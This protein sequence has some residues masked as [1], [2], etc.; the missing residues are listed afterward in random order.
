MTM[1]MLQAAGMSIV[2]DEIRSADEDNPKG[3]FELERVKGLEK[4]EDKSWLEEARGKAIKIISF[5]LKDLPVTNNYKVLF[6]NRHLEEVLASQSKMLA[7]RG[8]S[9]E[10][11]DEK[12]RELYENHLWKVRYLMKH[13]PHLQALDIH[14]REVLANPRAEAE[15]IARFIGLDLDADKMASTVDEQ[16][17]RN[18]ADD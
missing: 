14:Y 8:E 6:M 12:M 15:R 13:Q 9:S 5:L 7:R 3:Y 16:L 18:R 4:D 1:K 11:N 17:Y 2:T 10:A